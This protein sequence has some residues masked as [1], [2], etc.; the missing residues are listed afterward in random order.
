MKYKKL[1]IFDL[2]QT[3]IDVV[4]FNSKAFELTF[5]KLF[6]IKSTFTKVNYPGKTINDL[7][8]EVAELECIKQ[9]NGKQI[10]KFIKLYEQNVKILL[11]KHLDKYILPGVKDLLKKLSE[12]YLLAIITG[13]PRHVVN[14]ILKSTKLKKYFKIILTGENARNKKKLSK[15]AHKKANNIAKKHLKPIII[16]DSTEDINAGKVINALTI[17]VT[18]GIHSR[19]RLLNNKANYVFNSLKNKSIYEIING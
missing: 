10:L 13:S 7:V 1:V 19:E 15:L 16:G 11:P 14:K 6:G 12:D 2:D 9:L 3:L 5:Q 8:N 18:T 4:S 17:G